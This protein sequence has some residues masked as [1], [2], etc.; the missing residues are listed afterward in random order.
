MAGY[1]THAQCPISLFTPARGRPDD[2][3]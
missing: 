1:V 3:R 2:P